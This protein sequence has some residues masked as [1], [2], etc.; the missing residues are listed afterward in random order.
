MLFLGA[1]S[2]A[3]GIA[4]LVVG[5]MGHEGLAE[6][7]ARGRCWFIDSKGLVVRSRTDLAAYKRPYAH[8]HPPAADSAGGGAG[9]Q[10]DRPDRRLGSARHLHRAGDQGDGGAAPAAGRSSRSR[11]QPPS[12]SARAEQAWRWSEG[13]AIFASGSPF[14]PF[15]MGDRTLLPGQANNAYIFP[16]LGL[17]VLAVGARRVTDAMFHAAARSLADQVQPESLASGTLFPP[18][19]QIGRSRPEWRRRS[20]RWPMRR[21]WRP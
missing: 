5:A 11:I 3:T 16:G 8:D 4:D 12:R 15:T 2:A 6:A 18:L 1:G 10:A 17:G 13:R 21:G 20:P 19:P 7:E 9:A 14:P